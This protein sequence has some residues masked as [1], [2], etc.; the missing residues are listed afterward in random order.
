VPDP[1]IAKVVGE[2]VL[3]A[4]LPLVEWRRAASRTEPDPQKTP[5]RRRDGGGPEWRERIASAQA[6]LR[7]W[8]IGELAG[9]GPPKAISGTTVEPPLA[10]L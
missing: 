2:T 9:W 7:S 6:I 8:A 1:R 5:L 4:Q 10:E 3:A